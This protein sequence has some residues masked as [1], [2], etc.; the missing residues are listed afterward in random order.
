MPLT[1]PAQR[2]YHDVF[3]KASYT[4]GT[5]TCDLIEEYG[6]HSERADY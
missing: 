1:S 3:N 2:N 5:Y 4:G 6:P